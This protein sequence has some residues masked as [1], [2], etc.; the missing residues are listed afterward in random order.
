MS[1]TIKHSPEL[2]AACQYINDLRIKKA[3]KESSMSVLL[4][5]EFS[6][7]DFNELVQSIADVSKLLPAEMSN[8]VKAFKDAVK[9]ALRTKTELNRGSVTKE[10]FAKEV[11]QLAGL[12]SALTSVVSDLKNIALLR[13]ATS[14]QQEADGG[15]SSLGDVLDDDEQDLVK[16]AIEDSF[17]PQGLWNTLF[18]QRRDWYGLSFDGLF[19]DLMNVTLNGLGKLMQSKEIPN[20]LKDAMS[21]EDAK[22]VA[23]EVKTDSADDS[24]SDSTAGDDDVA[25]D[26]IK[27]D[28]EE[29]VDDEPATDGKVNLVGTMFK[30]KD[31]DDPSKGAEFRDESW[32]EVVQAVV[33]KPNTKNRRRFTS[34][35]NAVVDRELFESRQHTALESAHSGKDK[36]ILER[37][38]KMAGICKD[39][40]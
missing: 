5:E 12:G 9:S 28:E 21:S 31:P 33:D 38:R 8:S 11:A 30:Y 35:M 29:E 7:S 19:D 34:L 26:D 36:I 13:D 2:A 37:W 18:K 27:S 32:K 6:S 40:E 10:Q 15:D 25:Q 23:D 14:R 16:S 17:K 3:L 24:E 20:A 39:R 4:T 1:D 22:E